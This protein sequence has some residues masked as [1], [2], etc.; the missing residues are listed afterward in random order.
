LDPD[1]IQQLFDDVSDGV[2]FLD[3]DR[4]I[5]FWSLGAERLTGYR[6]EDV[7]G[8]MCFDGLLAHT[9][10]TGRLL[11][12]KPTCPAA[13]CMRN[14]SPGQRLIFF[15]HRDG[16]RVPVHVHSRPMID[17]DGT[18]V[19]AAEVFRVAAE[20]RTSRTRLEE[21]EQ[22]ALLDP[23]TGVGNRRLGD[24]EL[25]GRLNEAERYDWK[26]GVL[27]VDIDGFKRVNDVHGHD[28][29]DE[30]LERVAQTL[31]QNVRS[32]DSVIRWGGDE[33]LVLLR[34][35]S[36]E[37]LL[38]IAEKLRQLIA[39]LGVSRGAIQL[40]VTVSVGATLVRPGDSPATLLRR[41]DALMYDG[42]HAGG[43][44]VTLDPEPSPFGARPGPD[45]RPQDEPPIDRA[46]A[47]AAS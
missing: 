12:G 23:L 5:T 46:G 34:N 41:A 39:G 3:A 22:M 2:Y 36:R 32:F 31:S 6:A 43:N 33:F 35:V 29:G 11:C 44:R 27:F 18:V 4:K 1:L 9:D 20:S 30:V 24:K 26:F 40:Q 19:G 45:C 13:T 16:R 28:A 17:R 37:P 25:A 42:K 14:G 7:V 10:T 8:R 21:L 38:S 47:R 15:T